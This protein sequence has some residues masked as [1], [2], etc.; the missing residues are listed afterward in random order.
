M[1]YRLFLFAL[2]MGLGVAV[3]VVL[4]HCWG[5]YTTPSVERH[6]HPLYRDWRPAGRI[7]HGLGIVGSG[8]VLLLLLYSLR[9]RWRPLHRLGR[10]GTWLD[11]HIFLGISG[12]LLITLHTTFKVHG[13]VAVS[14]WSMVVVACSGVFGR[15]LYRQLPR[16]VL[17]EPLSPDEMARECDRLGRELADRYGWDETVRE[18]LLRLAT[19]DGAPSLLTLPL[20]RR[21]LAGA[22][23]RR[24]RELGIAAA[25]PRL[26]EETVPWLLWHRRLALYDRIS[27]LFHYWHVLHKPLAVTMIVIMLVHVTVAVLMGYRWVL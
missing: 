14:Y 1:R 25:T 13:L 11:V 4:V 10:L 9:K 5:F 21:S 19:S 27:E 6:L 2:Y 3:T 22:L 20:A 17:G 8:Q 18:R 12:P 16:N 7:G 26:V 15:F 24:G 23:R